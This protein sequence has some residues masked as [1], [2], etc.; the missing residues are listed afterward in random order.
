MCLLVRKIEQAKWRP[1]EKTRVANIPSDA[2]TS[3]MRTTAN[4]LSVWEVPLD[5]EEKMINEGVLALVSGPRQTNLESI[6]IVLL[7]PKELKKKRLELIQKDEP[8]FV[9]DFAKAH[10]NISHLTY[11]KLGVMAK[12][13]IK[14]IHKEKVVR[15]TRT[16]LT[17]IVIEAIKQERLKLDCLNEKIQETVRKRCKFL[18]EDIL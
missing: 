6:D 1:Q 11:K 7:D 8:T 13:I 15:K 12:V 9:K 5:D 4:A 14:K 18:G 3:C 10:W 16:E 17:D 2:I